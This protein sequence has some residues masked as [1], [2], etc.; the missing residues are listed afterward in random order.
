[1]KGHKTLRY[2]RSRSWS[3]ILD[4]GYQ[5]DAATGN[6]TRKQKWITFH[7]SAKE[8]DAKLRELLTAKDTGTFVAPH[9]LTVGEWLTQWW[10]AVVRKKAPRTADS[11][12]GAI[13]GHLI[14]K[15]GAIRL[16]ALRSINLEA[17][18]TDQQQPPHPLSDATLL[19]HHCIMS[20]A[21]KAA[22]R[23]GLVVRNVAELVNNKPRPRPLVSRG[24]EI[25][26]QCWTAD[27]AQKIQ[28]AAETAGIQAAAFYTLALATGMRKSELGGMQWSD[29]NL[30]TATIR[31]QRQIVTLSK[32]GRVAL[33][34]TTPWMFG[35]TKGK[36]LRASRIGAETVAL[37][38]RHKANQ[39]RLKL[40]N[41]THYHDHG[42]VFAR[43]YGGKA[44]RLGEPLELKNVG[45]GEF[46]RLIKAADVPRIKFHGMRHTSATLALE[47]GIAVKVVQE[48]LGHTKI[49]TTADIYQHVSP[50]MDQQAGDT[51]DAVIHRGKR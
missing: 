6:R 7:G 35:P 33:G 31:V 26:A 23:S 28:S 41:G 22:V 2:P 50:A 19:V 20:G 18:Y 14:P 38:R 13:D 48:R 25:G 47:E 9:K 24:D 39:A 5:V 51:L 15:L 30:A 12:K 10:S 29:V 8:A 46:G 3:L 40:Q 16:Q 17:Y 4:L 37:L 1:M 42:L 34:L 21:L 44:D 27:E 43:E 32:R 49:T 36:R 45:R 11:Y